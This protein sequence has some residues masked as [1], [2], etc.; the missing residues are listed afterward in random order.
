M[1][2]DNARRRENEAKYWA[3]VKARECADA[4]RD[5]RYAHVIAALERV[6]IDPHELKAYLET[7]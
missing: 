1:A 6:G 3:E 7:L 5:E 4:K 2:R